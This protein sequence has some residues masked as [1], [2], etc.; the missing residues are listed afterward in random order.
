VWQRKSAHHSVA[1]QAAAAAAAWH[2]HN[3]QQA[4]CHTLASTIN[5]AAYM[6]V[7]SIM[8]AKAFIM[9]QHAAGS[10]ASSVS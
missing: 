10:A 3:N 1:L 9:Q 4:A 6:W 2:Q 7:A 8:K 5:S